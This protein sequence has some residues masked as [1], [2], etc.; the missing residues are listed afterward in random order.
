MSSWSGSSHCYRLYVEDSRLSAYNRGINDAVANCKLSVVCDYLTYCLMGIHRG[1]LQSTLNTAAVWGLLIETATPLLSK[2]LDPPDAMAKWGTLS[3]RVFSGA[4]YGRDQGFDLVDQ[5]D[6]LQDDMQTQV[7][8]AMDEA[9]GE[10]DEN[11]FRQN[12]A[13]FAHVG[14]WE[15][16]WRLYQEVAYIPW[17]TQRD[18]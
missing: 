3:H 16:W 18:A 1:V 8:D 5:T 2:H 6:T 12:S 9:R 17:V 11:K 4:V 13:L 7:Y 15:L 14:G 10:A